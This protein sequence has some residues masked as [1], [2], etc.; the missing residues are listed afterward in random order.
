MNVLAEDLRLR[1]A[2]AFPLAW[3]AAPALLGLSRL[4]SATGFG[5]GLRLGAATACLLIPGALVSRA[6]RLDGLSP[7]FVWSLAALFVGMALMFAVHGSIWLPLAVLGAVALAAAPFAARRP[8]PRLVPWTIGVLVLGLAAGITLWWVAAYGGDTFFHLGRIR[9]LDDL[10]SLSL[11]TLDEYRDGGLHPGYAFPLWHG[12]LALVAKLAGVDPS[13]VV[14]HGPTVLLPLSFGLTYEAGA[15]LFRSRWAGL[16]ALLAQWALLGLAP[17]HGGAFVSLPLAADA[18]RMLVLP[19]LLA[20]VFVYVREPSWPLLA[21]IAAAAGAMTL[22]H[23]PH[24][25]LVLLVLAGFLFARVLLNPRGAGLLAAAIAA[26][27][28]PTAAVGLWLLP[29]V[30]ETV[31]HNPGHSE[32]RR[33]FANYPYE[34]DVFGLHSYRLKPELFGRTGAVAVA[35][36]VL[37]PLAL[38]ARRR[39]WSAFVLGGMLLG[40][41]V[42]LSTFLF[43]HLA[44]ALSISQARRLVG[45]TPRAFAFAGGLLV[46]AR[47][48]GVLVLPLA[49]AAGAI[50]QWQL[51]GDFSKPYHHLHGGPPWLTWASFAVA[52]V[53]LVVGVLGRRLVPELERDGWLVASA[54]ALFVLPVAIHGYSHWSAPV[55]AGKPL[56]APLVAALRERLPERA[57]VFSDAA[58]GYELVAALPVYVNAT[59]PAHSSDT[60]ANHPVR[61]VNDAH[62]FFRNHGPL[63]VLHRYGAGWLLV[64]RRFDG[65]KRFKL[66]RVWT[67][68]R[69]VLYRVR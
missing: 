49:L 10:G 44:D 41:A 38:F 1:F 3:L 48:L 28:V 55:S 40:L 22:I 17:G 68:G 31:A 39:L 50:L 13:E 51:P 59:P 14:L 6:F 29:I 20:L 47:L 12:F 64:D 27:A 53:A 15:A 26:V 32:L 62:R 4:L 33:A 21:T 66:P 18:S 52:A 19:A 5:L 43:P 46:L 2:P 8:S 58:T 23:P 42:A 16:A 69:Y 63:S 34:L 67:D 54:A 45:F 30:R 35:A 9:K 60:R 65:R 61:R 36:L 11:R 25:A 7:V 24:S 57:V 37:L 56:P